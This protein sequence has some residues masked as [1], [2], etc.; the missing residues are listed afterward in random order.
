MLVWAIH[1]VDSRDVDVLDGT[2]CDEVVILL[3][4]GGSPVAAMPLGAEAFFANDI[5]Q[6]SLLLVVPLSPLGRS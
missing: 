5:L 4:F 6:L 3:S 1:L 2:E